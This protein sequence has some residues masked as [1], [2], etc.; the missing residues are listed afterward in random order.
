[1]GR[2]R[3]KPVAPP[4][5]ASVAISRRLAPVHGARLAWSYVAAILGGM[6]A[7]LG[8]AIAEG[9]QSTTCD[10][11]TCSLGVFLVGGL[12]G[13]LVAVSVVAP[14][15]RLGWEWWLVGVTAVLAMPTILDLAGSWGWLALILAPGIAAL[16]TWTGPER[17]RWRPWVI[18]GVCVLISAL[19]LLGT[20][21][22]S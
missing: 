13:G 16:A 21:L 5:D 1:M 11:A 12:I 14:L 6:I 3:A 19:V 10:D 15:F 7:G 2:K 20:F 4:L 8:A 18:A 17:S 9:I 22:D